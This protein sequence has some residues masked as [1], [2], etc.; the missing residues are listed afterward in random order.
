MSPE[1]FKKATLPELQAREYKYL[2]VGGLRPLNWAGDLR[3][4]G[5]RPTLGVDPFYLSQTSWLN[6]P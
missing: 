1:N 5:Q 2:I 6:V 3:D 4:I